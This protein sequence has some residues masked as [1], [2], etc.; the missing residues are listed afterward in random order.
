MAAS[1]VS[2]DSRVLRILRM[3]EKTYA[4]FSSVIAAIFLTAI[5]LIVGLWSGSLGILSEA[6]HSALD[7]AAAAVTLFAVRS[8]D[9]PPDSDHPY[10]H[11]KIESL[12]ALFE[13]LLLLITVV[14]IIYE[15]TRRI[16]LN[17]LEIINHPITFIVIIIAI[18]IDYSR[19]RLLYKMANKYDSQALKAD[20]LHFSTDILSSSVVFIGLIFAAF[21]FPLGDPIAAIGVALIVLSMTVNLGKET[22][23]SLLDRAPIGEKE[24]VQ[25]IAEEVEGVIS[26]EK[27]RIRKSGAIFFVDLKI[28]V[29]PNISLE[30]AH[31]IAEKVTSEI[32]K[33]I[34]TADV[35]IHMD[36]TSEDLT[37][38]IRSIRKETEKYSWIKHIHKIIAFEFR[39]ELLI[40]FHIH[41]SGNKSLGEIHKKLDRE[42]QP[43]IQN[44]D[45]RIKEESLTIHIEPFRKNIPTKFDAGV[46]KD[47]IT[48]MVRNSTV[49]HDFHKYEFHT[50]P[51]GVIISFHCYSSPELS[52]LDV[53]KASSTLETAIKNEIRENSQIY[54]FV[55]PN[56]QERIEEHS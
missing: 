53:H 37:P 6:L 51:S 13:T 14:W 43:A 30:K 20:A 25:T 27:I 28:V 38:I 33:V 41:V 22:V 19:S 36:P 16:L 3:N 21:G 50:L 55:E 31:R 5:K 47:K 11:G 29:S 52:I 49:L 1:E 39:E 40:R 26:C 44:I 23:D 18:V 54:I 56:P 45:S 10:G 9:R 34:P 46:L 35:S 7:L 2:T 12:S 42:F 48:T 17:D 32:Q 24:K 4:A 15:A 8:S